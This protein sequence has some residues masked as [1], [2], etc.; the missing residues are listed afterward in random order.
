MA[1][2]PQVT[3]ARLTMSP[4]RRMKMPEKATRKELIENL[5]YALNCIQYCRKNHPDTQKGSGLPIERVI[6]EVLSRA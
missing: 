5:R 2:Q 6:E 4:E 3:S 1:A